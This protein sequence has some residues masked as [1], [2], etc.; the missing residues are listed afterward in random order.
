MTSVVS[1]ATLAVAFAS[2]ALATPGVAQ[3]RVELGG[4]VG[5]YLPQGSFQHTPVGSTLLAASPDQLS[6]MALG[7]QLR[8]WVARIGV[9]LAATTTSSRAGGDLT[10]EGYFPAIPARVSTRS[11]QLL[12][13]LTGDGGRTRAW[14]GAGA[15][16]IRHGG[17]AYEPFGTPLNYEGV[18]GVGSAIRIIAGMSADLGLTSMI[19]DLNVRG[20]AQNDPRLSERG[21]QVDLLLHT[22]LSY[23]WH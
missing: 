6:G 7:A 17:P 19:Y 5:A 10:P 8:V 11:A 21:R 12:F 1:R 2:L 20:S 16:A 15:G 23:S 9:Q 3:V 22:G 13:R 4:T 14:V 18:I